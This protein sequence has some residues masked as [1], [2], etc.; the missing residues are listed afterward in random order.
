MNRPT[1]PPIHPTTHPYTYPKVGC[2]HSQI[3]KQN[4]IISIRSVLLGPSQLPN[5]S[6]GIEISRT[7]IDANFTDLG[8]TPLGG[9]WVGAPP[10]MYRHACMHVHAHAQG[11]WLPPWWRPFA[12]SLL[13]MCMHAHQYIS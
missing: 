10:C 13:A 4:R 1:D 11:T 3:F 9:G 7:S 5:A 8:G 12:I 2:V 6:N